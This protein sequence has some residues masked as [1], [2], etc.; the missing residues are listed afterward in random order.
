MRLSNRISP[1]F[2]LII[3]I[4]AAFAGIVLVG[5]AVKV[6]DDFNLPNVA[7]AQTIAGLVV[8]FGLA[9]LS[10]F[11]A[12]RFVRFFRLAKSASQQTSKS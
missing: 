4:V 8:I 12:Y 6:T 9:A 10:W 3:G 7:R 1:S 11:E 2:A 5:M